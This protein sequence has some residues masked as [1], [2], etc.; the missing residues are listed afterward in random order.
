M[1][2]DLPAQILSVLADAEHAQTAKQLSV[3]I[4]GQ[5]GTPKQVN[6]ELYRLLSQKKITKTG[7]GPVLWSLKKSSDNGQINQELDELRNLLVSFPDGISAADLKAHA[8]DGK[9]TKKEI[10]SLLYKL[11]ANGSVDSRIG[12]DGKRPIWSAV[13]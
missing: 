5:G 6:P 11:K 2:L 10:N 3:N 8:F 13:D 9:K 4:F 12:D 1:A 7:T